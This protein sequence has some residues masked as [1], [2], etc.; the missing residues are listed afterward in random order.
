LEPPVTVTDDRLERIEDALLHPREGVV[1]R[2]ALLTHDLPNIYKRLDDHAMHIGVLQQRQ[3]QLDGGISGGGTSG[4]H[5]R[6]TLEPEPT[7]TESE[8]PPR[9][10]RKRGVIEK[11]IEKLPSPTAVATLGTLLV[12]FVGGV[13]VQWAAMTPT[14]A[15][16]KVDEARHVRELCADEVDNDGDRI[17]DCADNDCA[18][19]CGLSP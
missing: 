17:V 12:A 11:V 16:T 19:D 4:Q 15:E 10:R 1:V 7:P 5:A 3:A 13:T 2:V 6:P 18:T 8:E 9:P 14:A